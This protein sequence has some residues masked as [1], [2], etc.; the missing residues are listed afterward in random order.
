MPQKTGRRAGQWE[1]KRSGWRR[2]TVGARSGK[3]QKLQVMKKKAYQS[4]E[5][6]AS[7]AASTTGPWFAVEPPPANP[8]PTK[9]A[10][11][12][13]WPVGPCDEEATQEQE[14]CFRDPTAAAR[15]LSCA[16]KP[17]KA[18]E[19]ALTRGGHGFVESGKKRAAARERPHGAVCVRRHRRP[20]PGGAESGR[21]GHGEGL[22]L[23]RPQVEL[24]RG[25]FKPPIGRAAVGMRHQPLWR[26]RG[27]NRA[28]R[29]GALR[30]SGGALAAPPR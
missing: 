3:V 2:Y 7:P 20:L 26:Q 21:C 17:T 27:R 8:S 22:P 29:R 6:A 11:E 5:G 16:L 30:S 9:H 23:F 28:R 25:V 19:E 15:A 10:A 18:R 12:R 1:F 14:A 13:Y 24:P 4:G